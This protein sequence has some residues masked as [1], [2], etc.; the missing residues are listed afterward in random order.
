MEQQKPRAGGDYVR[1]SR[2]SVTH[3]PAQGASAPARAPEE[4]AA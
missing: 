4:E 2:G 1:T 3:G